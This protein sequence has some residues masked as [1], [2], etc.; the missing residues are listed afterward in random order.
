MRLFCLLLLLITLRFSATGQSSKRYFDQLTTA[1]G[2]P[3][4]SVIALLQDQLGF[5]WLGTKNGLV[6]YDGVTM[7]TFVYNPKDPYSLKSR[8]IVCLYEDR[9][10]D[11]WVGC[12]GGLYRFEQATQRFISYSPKGED[13]FA[14][15]DAIYKI[16]QDKTGGVWVVYE[17]AAEKLIALSRY[18]PHTNT[19]THY[20]HQPGNSRSLVFNEV[21]GSSATG[22]RRP[23]FWEDAQGGIWVITRNGTTQDSESILH[24]YDHPTDAFVPYRPNGISVTNPAFRYLK[25]LHFDRKG[26]LWQCTNNQGLFRI[27]PVSNRVIAHY[28]HNPQNPTS[29]LSDSLR[30]VYEDRAGFLWVSTR[31][32]LDR[33][34]PKTGFF[35]HFLYDPANPHA[36]HD[37]VLDAIGETANGHIWFLTTVGGLDEYDYKT[38]QFTRYDVKPGHPGSLVGRRYASFL[39]DHTD[40]IW[41]GTGLAWNGFGVVEGSGVN[42][43]SRMTR[44]LPFDYG[45]ASQKNSHSQTATIVYEAPTN[46]TVRWIGTSQ[47][48]DRYD[49]KTGQVIQYPLDLKNPYSFGSDRVTALVEDAKKR[50][51]VGTTNGVYQLDRQRGAFTR[52]AQIQGGIVNSIAHNL[53]SSLLAARD[54]TLWIGTKMGLDQYNP[55]TNLFT[56]FYQAD[57]TYHP[58][59]FRFFSAIDTP[60]HRVAAAWH[61]TVHPE[62]SQSFTL[63]EPTTLAVSA[64]GIIQLTTKN[65]YGWIDDAAGHLVWEMNYSRTRMAGSTN[66]IQME[67]IRL[68]AGSYRL[69]YK[70]EGAIGVGV[71]ASQ[72][73]ASTSYHPELWGI[74]VIRITPAEAD[75]L[76]RLTRKWVFNGLSTSEVRALH[77]DKKGVIWIGTGGGGLNR[78]D[79]STGQFTYYC[80]PVN[81]LVSI[82]A[83]HED[84]K[85]NLWLGDYVHGLFSFDPKTGRTKRYSTAN[86]LSHNSVVAIQAD[87]SGY[88]WLSTYNGLSRF[89]PLTQ[90][91]RTYTPT[92]GLRGMI[93]RY[94]SFKSAEGDLFFPSNQGINTLGKSQVYNDPYPPRVVLTSIDIFNQ[95]ARI[96]P[97]KPLTVP[98]SV[99]DKITLASSQ[100]DVTF[101]FAALHFNRSAE[102]RYAVK[103]EP[104]DRN[105]VQTGTTRQIRYLALTPGTYTFRVKAANADGLWNQKGVSIHVVVLAPRWATGWAYVLY[106]FGLGGLILGFIRY[107]IRQG[108]QRQEIVFQQREAK[109][110]LALDELKTRF[111]SNITHEFRT[112]LTL[113]IA[114]AEKL[115]QE[116]NLSTTIHHSLTLIQQ[117]AR[118]LLQLINQLLDLSKLE[119]GSMTIT[120]FQGDVT[121]FVRHQVDMFQPMA[122]QK[123]ITL[124]FA[125]DDFTEDYV[126]D[127]TKWERILSNLLSNALKFTPDKGT[128]TLR[129]RRSALDRIEL[130]VSD[131]GIGI[132]AA[133]LPHIFERFYQVGPGHE[134]PRSVDDLRTRS[135]TGTGIGLSLVKELTELLGGTVRVTSEVNIGTQVVVNLPIRETNG[136]LAPVIPPDLFRPE[137]SVYTSSDPIL[138]VDDETETRPLIL[139]VEDHADLRDFIRDCLSSEFRVLT[140]ANGEEGW[141]LALREVPDVVISDLMMPVQAG[142]IQSGPEMD[143][144]QLCQRLKTDPATDH[145]AVVLLTART[146]QESRLEGLL[147]GADEY[148]TKPFNS[149]EL[150]V[151][152]RNIVTYQHKLRAHYSYPLSSPDPTHKPERVANP[153][154]QQVYSLL[155]D[156][157]DD[158][159]FGVDELATSLAM[160]RRT[161]YRKLAVLLNLSASDLIQQYRLKRA[162]ELLLAGH[163][164]SQTAYQVGFES[165]Q[166]FAKVFKAFYKYTPT[167]FS[168]R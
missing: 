5:M 46:S 131:T 145:I 132:P 121:E 37:K 27:D 4:N 109:R 15:K 92:H 161:L 31:K 90:R 79:P 54:S 128:V 148:L 72:F 65:E 122:D 28:R 52:M 53:T 20:R 11:I 123:H 61:S 69:H 108:H 107:R 167:Q 24:R 160:S 19:W 143:G 66:R 14:P 159:S 50:F 77:Q 118:Q 157:L 114:P 85:G 17:K 51:W 38:G 63:K 154:L 103:L 78:Y 165:P 35:T 29:L 26:T 144:Y 74:Q 59:L 155:D 71:N 2:L 33:L 86:G 82:S 156:R 166:Y 158:S 137:K 102:C 133:N 130:S 39:I 101:H 138:P 139:I 6:R 135:T 41:A 7:T 119:A 60:D 149:L 111:F 3:E 62:V 115:L 73:T 10:G 150:Q 147:Y 25:G 125:T 1:D 163:P 42:K 64:M 110:L 98:S 44:F 153:F 117:N 81:G 57:T 96:G 120:E 84:P 87:D 21:S 106:V 16:H 146:S 43:Q 151:R 100:N 32:G 80:E 136:Q 70:S 95:Q 12:V 89:D 75:R 48:V 140:A 134:R 9:Q 124:L 58:D 56:H 164:I 8:S 126:F 112:P 49:K 127:T 22:P 76:T 94:P 105:W 168:H 55:E 129:L 68:P 83:I 152:I 97:D 47:G 34:D 67:T 45:S 113:I 88:L 40:L 23:A 162:A 30:T 13:A 104:Y 36:P 18:N 99:A 116:E 142:T 93:F 141:Q 91:F